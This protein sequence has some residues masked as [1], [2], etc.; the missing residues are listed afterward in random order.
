[1]AN[2]KAFF[3]SC[4]PFNLLLRDVIDELRKEGRLQYENGG[5]NEVYARENIVSVDNVNRWTGFHHFANTAHSVLRTYTLTA[6]N[7]P[8]RCDLKYSSRSNNVKQIQKE[9]RHRFSPVTEPEVTRFIAEFD[10]LFPPY[11]IRQRMESRNSDVLKG[12]LTVVEWTENAISIIHRITCTL[13]IIKRESG[14][15]I[16]KPHVFYIKI[17]V[18]KPE[19]NGESRRCSELLKLLVRHEREQGQF[20]EARDESDEEEEKDLADNLCTK[21]NVSHPNI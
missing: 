4:D 5:Y 18:K 1:M 20:E 6:C 16:A 12:D 13:S 9:I 15:V 3:V 10:R 8:S 11:V 2:S 14:T 21:C 7:F 19:K 17:N